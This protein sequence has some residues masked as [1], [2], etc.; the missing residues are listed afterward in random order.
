MALHDW[1][2][3][4]PG[5]SGPPAVESPVAGYPWPTF[6]SCSSLPSHYFPSVPRTSRYLAKTSRKSGYQR[7]SA[8]VAV[9]GSQ[10]APT[11]GNEC[12]DFQA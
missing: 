5:S 4:Q 6:R 9:H 8:A 10:D 3:Q 2:P 7:F 1:T 11:L 12:T